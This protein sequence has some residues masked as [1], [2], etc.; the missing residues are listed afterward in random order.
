[1]FFVRA[2]KYMSVI[3]HVYACNIVYVNGKGEGGER[4]EERD[5]LVASS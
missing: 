5:P 3:T 4:E 2:S 1:M